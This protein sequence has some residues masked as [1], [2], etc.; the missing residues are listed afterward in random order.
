MTKKEFNTALAKKLGVTKKEADE[1]AQA[2]VELVTETLVS[3]E[4]LTIGGLGVFEVR[5]RPA[6]TTR[7]PRTGES[8]EL[9]ERRTVT[10]KPAAA[11]KEEMK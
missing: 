10:F 7:N 4:K 3:G 5:T 9:P 2:F 11:L 1:T 8:V 6:R